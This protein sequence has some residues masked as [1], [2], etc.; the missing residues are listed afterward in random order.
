MT[1]EPAMALTIDRLVPG[2]TSKILSR[3]IAI[4]L[5]SWFDRM[6]RT[7]GARLTTARLRPIFLPF[8]FVGIFVGTR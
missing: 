7:T 1:L 3:H 4:E 6:R 5:P 8:N 2:P